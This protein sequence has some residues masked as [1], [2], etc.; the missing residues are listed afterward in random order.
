M[1]HWLFPLT[2]NKLQE[3]Y[4]D[5]NK[6]DGIPKY[7]GNL[8]GLI[9]LSINYNS[10]SVKFSDLMANLSS[11]C[12]SVALEGLYVSYNQLT[13][14]LSDNVQ[15]FSSLR[16]LLLSNN[17][18]NG[19]ISENVWQLPKLQVLDVSSNSLKSFI[20]EYIGETK[21][22]ELHPSNNSF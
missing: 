10:M 17:E 15:K 22:L 20:S 13:G 7:L 11:G 6:L 21:I 5:G 12:T 9:Y 3:L 18:L 19:S 2:S 4:L 1:Y 16:H 8:C 14:S